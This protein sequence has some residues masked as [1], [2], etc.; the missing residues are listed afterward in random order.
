MTEGCGKS[1]MLDLFI[2]ETEQMLGE[3]E[4]IILDGEKTGGL[5]TA[6]NEVFRIMHTIKGS[7]AMML[8]DNISALAH[9]LE[10]VFYFLREFQLRDVDYC[11][12]TDTVLHA[13]DFIKNEIAKVE[14]GHNPDGAPADLI[15]EIGIFLAKL[16]GQGSPEECK[17]EEKADARATQRYYISPLK[18]EDVAGAKSFE[19]HVFFDESCDMENVR[20]FMLIHELKD[21]TIDLQFTPP[22]II[23][24][25]STSE[26]IRQEGFKINICTQ[27]SPE[28]IQACFER[29]M[30]LK[31]FE[32]REIDPEEGR[33]N[34][35]ER[36]TIE[37]EG[38]MP[39]EALWDRP[40]AKEPDNR[41]ETDTV[42]ATKTKQQ[43]FISV[44]VEKMDLLMDLVGELVVAEAMVTQNPELK[45]L[46][47]DG[48]YKA[49]R[50][51]HKISD[52]LQD[53]VMSVRM[54]PL[55]ATF[56][57]M[58][59]VVRDMTKKL[60][61]QAELVIAGEDTEVDK[62]I[63]EH[64]SDP[65]MHL[66]RNALDHGIE[67]AEERLAKGKG[68]VGKIRL[69]AKNAGGDVWIIVQDDGG[70][71]NKEKILQKALMRGLVQK[72]D[73][74]LTDKE[75][76][77][78]ILQPGFSLKEAV[79]E[80]SGR[81]V[82]LDV[83]TKNIEKVGGSVSIDSQPGQGT[84]ISLRIP[85][86]LAIIEGMNVQVGN[87]IYTIPIIAVREALCLQEHNVISDTDG[88]EMILL[89]GQCYP[90]VRLHER[91]QIKQSATDLRD[92][93]MLI[94][95]ADGEGLGLFADT[96]LGQQQVVVKALPKY[97]KKTRGI[98]GCT[99][100]GDGSVSLILDVAGLMHE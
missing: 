74:T 82:G 6:I 72:I 26:I 98:G 11:S 75:I 76:Y 30:F 85:L 25:P 96:L 35:P 39:E 1:P 94:V 59:R 14:D 37:L 56:Q 52:E 81:G 36:K 83:V 12:L 45:G 31:S 93:V 87:A 50:Q 40:A 15:E 51:L 47:L 9:S 80:Y 17:A 43:R 21:I 34:T 20:A 57:K 77:A 78:L 73:Q 53:I 65:L 62:N 58:S 2:F 4:R 28:D 13:V 16:K 48:F 70:G 54:V 49:A 69:T 55:A 60:H 8:F 5:E 95:E 44:N 99:F 91:Y 88:R 18:T 10:D 42:A 97:I 71:L 46:N 61:K 92:G 90:V 67:S 79:T 100:L 68:P 86:T 3:L 41:Q 29:A 7:S 32:F 23:E 24:D 66:I 38:P 63:I 89:R 33:L 19:A 84:T 27:E 22:N 64:I